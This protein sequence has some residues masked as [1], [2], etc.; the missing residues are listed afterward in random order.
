MQHRKPVKSGTKL[1]I[2]QQINNMQYIN[3]RPVPEGDPDT[4]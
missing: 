2:W 3:I 4:I 1:H